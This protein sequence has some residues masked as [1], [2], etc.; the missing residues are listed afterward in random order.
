MWLLLAGINESDE[1]GLDT[2]VHR[3][4]LRFG[5]TRVGDL[6]C[7]QGYISRSTEDQH[8][9]NIHDYFLID[10]DFYAMCVHVATN[11]VRADTGGCGYVVRFP[12]WLYRLF[13]LFRR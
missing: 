13:T 10:E 7:S 1:S 8:A 11:A 4:Q 6:C 5:D 12:R 2:I 3:Y 9:P